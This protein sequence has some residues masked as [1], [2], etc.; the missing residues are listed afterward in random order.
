MLENFW[1]RK[2]KPFAG[3][4]GFGGGSAGLVVTGG[5]GMSVT[6]GNSTQTFTQDG[7]DYKAH[8]FIDNSTDLVIEGSPGDIDIMVVGGGGGGG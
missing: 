3:F 8:I 1:H 4:A 5:G 7:T 6:G 2:E